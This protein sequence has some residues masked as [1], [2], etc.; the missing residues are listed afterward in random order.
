LCRMIPSSDTNKALSEQPSKTCAS[1]LAVGHCVSA[2]SDIFEWICIGLPIITV[3]EI[4]DRN[5]VCNCNC[6]CKFTTA[7]CCDE[8]LLFLSVEKM[9]L[10]WN[11][12][13]SYK[14]NFKM[15][16]QLFFQYGGIHRNASPTI[17]D[18]LPLGSWLDVSQLDE[19]IV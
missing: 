10:K 18:T 4:M 13:Q 8:V 12:H 14:S 16:G 5:I 6:N 2:S 7:G 17:H 9:K 19:Q 15:Q 1:N 3:N 11:I